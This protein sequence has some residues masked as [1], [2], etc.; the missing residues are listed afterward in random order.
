MCI[1]CTHSRIGAPPCSVSRYRKAGIKI[2]SRPDL[3]IQ[4]DPG[5]IGWDP[6]DDLQIWS[7]HQLQIAFHTARETTSYSAQILVV[8]HKI[9]F[10]PI[11]IF[12]IIWANWPAKCIYNPI[13]SIESWLVQSKVSFLWVW[14][15]PNS[16]CKLLYRSIQYIE[17]ADVFQMAQVI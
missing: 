2:S 1:N 4:D 10:L 12:P 9:M 15:I 6:P 13:Q 8:L 16:W 3:P 5:V 14:I 11:V 17:S 7:I